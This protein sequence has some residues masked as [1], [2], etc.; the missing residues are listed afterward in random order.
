MRFV[1]YGAGAIGGSIGARLAQ[2][3]HDPVLIARGAHLEAMQRNGLRLRTPNEDIRIPVTAVGHPSEVDWRGDEVVLLTMKSQHTEDAL[4]ALRAAAGTG[5]PVVCAQNAVENERMAARRFRHVY[6]MLI[7]MPATFLD[8]G[9]VLTIGVD[10]TG[11]LP[12]GRYPSDV[13]ATIEAVCATLNTSGFR[14][15]AEPHTLRLKYAKLLYV[16]LDNAVQAACGT[17]GG[18]E[19]LSRLLIEEGA[20]VLDAAGIDYASSE[21]FAERARMQ[22]GAIEGF[23]RTAGGSTWQS[24][25]RAAG[26][27]ETDFLNGEILL[28]SVL[29]G[30]EAP[31]NRAMQDRVARMLASGEPAGSVPA[32]EVLAL[33]REYSAVI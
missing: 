5:V 15:W 3:G 27:I 6:S 22:R 19:H 20:R 31:I 21:E 23:D 2:H 10:V 7:Q 18:T 28:L 13:D 30:I 26:S 4:E 14:S 17:A 32:E 9:E 25:T 1:I 33:A 11:V 29:H 12:A 16:N 8:P 24:L